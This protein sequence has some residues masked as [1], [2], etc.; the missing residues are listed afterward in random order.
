ML[1]E[2]G[3]VNHQAILNTQLPSEIENNLL[4]CMKVTKSVMH[5]YETIAEEFEACWNNK[6]LDQHL[7]SDQP[8][9]MNYTYS[10]RG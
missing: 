2:Q 7:N 10:S 9:V 4:G 8:L 5:D 1:T 3:Q 6:K